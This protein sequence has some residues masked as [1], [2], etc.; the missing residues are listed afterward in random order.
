MCSCEVHGWASGLLN[1]QLFGRHG[2]R[3]GMEG[4]LDLGDIERFQLDDGVCV[5]KVHCALGCVEE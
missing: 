4:K 3:S 2:S 5:Q 1:K